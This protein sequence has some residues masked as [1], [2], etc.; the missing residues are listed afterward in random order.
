M[1][2]RE[3]L[4][5]AT[6]EIHNSLE[7]IIQSGKLLDELDKE[8]YK[9]LLLTHYKMIS[10]LSK[11]E[12]DKL[13]SVLKEMKLKKAAIKEDLT[14]LNTPQ[15]NDIDPEE[16]I[17]LKSLAEKIGW[18]YVSMGSQMGNRMM[19]NEM[20]KKSFFADDNGMHYMG[21]RSEDTSANWKSLVALINE[22]PEDS[23]PEL[24]KAAMDAFNHFKELWLESKKL[25]PNEHYL[26]VG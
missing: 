16:K 5:A 4:K 12:T 22:I 9:A 15:L 11:H 8:H 20:K 18:L 14:Y 2:N 21:F 25:L 24:E 26:Q 7:N 23:Y 19:Y 3:K 1:E 6:S 17:E 13:E 10:K